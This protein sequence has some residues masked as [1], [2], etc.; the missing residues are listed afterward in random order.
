MVALQ[1]ADSAD[2]QFRVWGRRQHLRRSS[3][4]GVGSSND[5]GFWSKRNGATLQQIF[6]IQ[7]VFPRAKEKLHGCHWRGIC[8]NGKQNKSEIVLVKM[9]MLKL[10]PNILPIENVPSTLLKRKETKTILRQFIHVFIN[11]YTCIV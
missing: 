10:W 11:R 4:V 2:H 5:W 6:F 1:T 8:V 9:K 3:N 7:E